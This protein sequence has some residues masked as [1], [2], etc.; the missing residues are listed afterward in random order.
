MFTESQL[1]HTEA[2]VME[3]VF[4]VLIALVAIICGLTIE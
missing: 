1:E 3:F 2:P 4:L